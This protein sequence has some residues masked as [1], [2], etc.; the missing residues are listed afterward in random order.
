VEREGRQQA[1]VIFLN[2][3]ARDHFKEIGEVS[4]D[5]LAR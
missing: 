5:D 1:S 4:R 3:V 2:V